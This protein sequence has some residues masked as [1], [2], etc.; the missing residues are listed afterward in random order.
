MTEI[1]IPATDTE[2]TQLGDFRAYVSLPEKV[3]D[4]P[5]LIVIQEIF[6]INDIM[7]DI[8]DAWAAKGYIAVCPDLFWRIEP[9]IELTD[10]TEEDW[11]RA[12][13]LFGK[14]DVDLGVKDIQATI[15]AVRNYEGEGR[16]VGALGFCLGGKLAYLSATR[17]DI[18]ASVGYYGVEIDKFVDEKTN[19]TK[20]LMLHIAE[21][22]GFVDKAAQ[23]K[24]KTGLD[25]HAFTTLHFYEGQDHAFARKGGDHYNED[26]ARLA[27]MRS[28]DF[29]K[30][31]LAR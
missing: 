11:A 25:D 13:E 18:D 1:R 7:R 12:F 10:K 30:E 29:L 19:I 9:N 16:K 2:Q 15:N 22:D 3:K 27:N 17:T 26:A 23:E 14:F 8:C 20:P 5:V 6:G 31:H 4:A 24:I 28:D 21:E